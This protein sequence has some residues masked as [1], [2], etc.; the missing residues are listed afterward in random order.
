MKGLLAVLILSCSLYAQTPSVAA[1]GVLNGASFD[2]NMP[3][4]PG[5]LI[6]I[7]G[8]NL[9]ATTATADSIQVADVLGGVK[10]KVNGVDAPLIGVFHTDNGDQINAQLPCSVSPGRATVVVTR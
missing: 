7:F 6:S 2:R 1:G 3:V 5:S 4:T 9:A 10:V 8:S